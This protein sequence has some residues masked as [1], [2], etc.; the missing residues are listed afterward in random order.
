MEQRNRNVFINEGEIPYDDNYQPHLP[1]LQIVQQYQQHQSLMDYEN[2]FVK[3]SEGFV[4]SIC[5]YK[6]R[7]RSFLLRHMSSHT[8]AKPYK[9]NYCQES[10]SQSSSLY[11]H[12]RKKHEKNTC[13]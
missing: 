4:C 10:Y 2:G 5:S 12:M 8:K 9:C 13:L 6:S 3:T 1:T 7:F 11:V